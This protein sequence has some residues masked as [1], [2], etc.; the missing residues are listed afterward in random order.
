MSAPLRP[1]GPLPA[2]VYWVRRAVVL[3]VPMVALLVVLASVI[4][5]GADGKD[6]TG[7]DAASLASG[8]PTGES[9]AQTTPEAPTTP[10]PPSTTKDAKPAL[11][12][13]EGECSPSDVVI[14]PDVPDP[15]SASGLRIDLA[16]RSVESEAC[17]FTVSPRTVSVG[18]T[19]GSDDIW[20]SRH[21]TDALPEQRVVARPTKAGRASLTWN[22]RRSDEECSSRTDWVRLGYYHVTAAALGG[23]PESVQ[24]RLSRPPAEVITKTVDPRDDE[25]DTKERRKR[26]RTD[27]GDEDSRHVEGDDGGGVSEPDE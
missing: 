3:G 5:G 13:P 15:I 7:G 12:E 10:V 8:T 20:F 24:F 19:S 6:G 25:K 2:R 27:R 26:G 1:K 11:A 16:V 9:A 18:I 4:G 17:W 14:T 23:E 22:L 21:C